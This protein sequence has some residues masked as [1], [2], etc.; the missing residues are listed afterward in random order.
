M[1]E[2]SHIPNIDQPDLITGAATEPAL[3]PCSICSKVFDSAAALQG[4]SMIHKPVVP[5]PECGKEYKT[6]GALGNHR[7]MTHGVMGPWAQEQE[8]KGALGNKPL[9]RPRGRPRKGKVSAEFRADDIVQAA[10]TLMW[11]DGMMPVRA[12]GPLIEWRDA[13]LQFLEKINSE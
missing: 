12:M 6:P 7:K 9:G 8:R 13:T 4:H 10:I 1:T 3:F 5:C 11:P 2:T